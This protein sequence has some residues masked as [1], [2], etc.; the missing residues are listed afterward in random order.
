MTLLVAQFVY[1]FWSPASNQPPCRSIGAAASGAVERARR[2]LR[3]G[4]G[5]GP[6]SGV[7]RRLRDAVALVVKHPDGLNE[8]A[9]VDAVG[10][11]ERRGLHAVGL[12]EHVVGARRLHAGEIEPPGLVAGRHVRG[13][14]V[15]GGR[16]GLEHLVTRR[17]VDDGIRAARSERGRIEA[18]LRAADDGDLR[19]RGPVAE[20][21]DHHERDVERGRSAVVRVAPGIAGTGLHGRGRV[22]RAVGGPVTRRE[23]RVGAR[24]GRGV[25]GGAPLGL[26]VGARTPTPRPPSTPRTTSTYPTSTCPT[27]RYRR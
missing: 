25:G 10:D 3:V 12:V 4:G 9:R 22:G 5:V 7:E 2:V 18:R 27:S 26:S 13:A 11:V 1:L 14:A 20:L 17:R 8:D 6:R 21:V 16:R 15:P 19:G 23:G 24:L